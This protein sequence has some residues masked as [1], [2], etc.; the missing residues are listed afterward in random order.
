MTRPINAVEEVFRAFSS[1]GGVGSN[2]MGI[3]KN[4][5]VPKVQLIIRSDT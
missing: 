3:L 5:L 4:G 1:S 2:S